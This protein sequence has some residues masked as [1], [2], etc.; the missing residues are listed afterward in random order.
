MPKKKKAKKRKSY[1]R[2]TN[3]ERAYDSQK[4]ELEELSK[5]KQKILKGY[6]KEQKGKGFFGRLG[7]GVKAAAATA[8][9]NKQ[10]NMRRQ[11]MGNEQKIK[12]LNQQ[13]KIVEAQAKLKKLKGNTDLD[14]SGLSPVKPIKSDD[15]FG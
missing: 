6:A 5:R 11:F 3:E 8:G 14:I 7:V 4:S 1:E 13:V 2:R 12:Q 10:M 15:I 9:I